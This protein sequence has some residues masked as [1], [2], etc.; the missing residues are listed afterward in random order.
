MMAFPSPPAHSKND[1]KKAAR[2]HEKPSDTHQNHAN[3][4]LL[5]R[6]QPKRHRSLGEILCIDVRII[7]MSHSDWNRV[8]PK[9]SREHSTVRIRCLGVRGRNPFSIIS[10][11][12][13]WIRTSRSTI[14]SV[15]IDR[16]LGVHLNANAIEV[17][18]IVA[19]L[20]PWARSVI[21][22][23]IAHARAFAVVVLVGGKEL[24]F[25][26]ETSGLISL[27]NKSHWESRHIGETVSEGRKNSRGCFV[28]DGIVWRYL[29]LRKVWCSVCI[30]D[31]TVLRLRTII[32]SK[33]LG[34][35]IVVTK[36][37]PILNGG[38]HGIEI[39]LSRCVPRCRGKLPNAN[40]KYART[41]NNQTAQTGDGLF[42]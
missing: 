27:G 38:V 8:E 11:E 37:V 23:S 15:Q 14:L 21:L 13:V 39:I 25:D 26:W 40:D 41:K 22:S 4:Q 20:A 35:E 32:S 17:V 31:D 10:G 36:F 3:E 7:V 12:S 24:Q 9:W 30:E 28:F 33:P 34:S 29:A 16:R 42:V 6:S 1:N 2:E 18:V 5:T 19:R